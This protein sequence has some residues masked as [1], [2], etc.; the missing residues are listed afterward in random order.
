M[1]N[2]L[3]SNRKFGALFTIVFIGL[4]AY[5]FYH[6]ASPIIIGL[7]LTLAVFFGLASLLNSEK[8]TP[9]NRLWFLLGQTMGKVISPIILGI[10]FF[11]LITPIA[12]IAKFLGRDE[13]RIKR[14]NSTTYWVNPVGSNSD[15]ESFKNQF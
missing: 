10:I 9:F 15:P 7:N 2:Q 11:V 3:P 5:S 4:T 14:P 1:N 8:L 6:H 12:V 13:L